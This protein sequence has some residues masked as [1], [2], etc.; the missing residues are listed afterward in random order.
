MKTA[1]L[2][3]SCVLDFTAS[4]CGALEGISKSMYDTYDK[5]IESDTIKIR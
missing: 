2:L 5:R 4:T 1:I 3:T